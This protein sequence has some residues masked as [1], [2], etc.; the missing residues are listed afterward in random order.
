MLNTTNTDNGTRTANCRNS[1]RRDS[2]RRLKRDAHRV[3]K[4]VGVRSTSAEMSSRCKENRGRSA[5]RRDVWNAN[6]AHSCC[7]FQMITG[8]KITEAITSATY[9]CQRNNHWR[10]GASR[11]TKRN[12]TGTSIPM[13]YLE[14]RPRPMLAPANNQA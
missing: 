13:V 12:A 14:M 11:S 5:S 8:E 9:G 4:P 1:Q 6:E 3:R 2:G 7:A 10:E